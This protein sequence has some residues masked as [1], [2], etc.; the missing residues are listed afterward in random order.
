M[1]RSSMLALVS[2]LGLTACGKESTRPLPEPPA[3]QSVGLAPYA[4]LSDTVLVPVTAEGADSVSLLVD[5]GWVDSDR[6]VPFELR[7][8]T[9]GLP[10]GSHRVQVVATNRG[11][12]TD[13]TL[14]IL[15]ENPGMGIG[16][17]V[18]PGEATVG[19]GD[20]RQFEAV[21]VGTQDKRV[22]WSVTSMTPPV[23]GAEAPGVLPAAVEPYPGS[24]DTTGLYTA[25]AEDHPDLWITVWAVSEA[26]PQ[27]V[28][29]ARIRLRSQP[30]LEIAVPPAE[31][32][33][34]RTYAL[35]TSLYATD[36][37]GVVWSL[38]GG[39]GQ[40]SITADGT[41]TAPATL[42]DPPE[43]TIRADLASD[44]GRADTVALPIRAEYGLAITSP[45]D[46]LATGVTAAFAAEVD[47]PSDPTVLWS[48]DGGPSH[49]TI[50]ADGTYTAPAILPD[51][52]AAV[53][54]AV[55]RADTLRTE[56]V[57]VDLVA[58]PD[59]ATLAFLDVMTQSGYALSEVGDQVIGAVAFA[60]RWAAEV[61]GEPAPTTGTL[62]RSGGDFVYENEPTDRFRIEPASGPI[63]TVHV[64]TME[65]RDPDALSHWSPYPGGG[66]LAYGTLEFDVNV[67]GLLSLAVSQDSRPMNLPYKPGVVCDPPARIERTLTGWIELPEAGWVDLDLSNRGIVADCGYPD[68]EDTLSGS[69]TLEG[70]GRIVFDESRQ[71]F[72]WESEGFTP[73]GNIWHWR[74]EDTGTL[75]GNTY[76][77]TDTEIRGQLVGTTMTRAG[78][79]VNPDDFAISGRLLRNGEAFAGV[80]FSYPV[81]VGVRPPDAV[82]DFG[83]GLTRVLRPPSA[84]YSPP[85]L[86]D[87]IP[88]P[89]R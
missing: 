81:R 29:Q 78:D 1:K 83:Y 87:L 27:A 11:G 73:G 16:L 60:L 9:A 4:I 47:G 25:P 74:F 49:G 44:P 13:T 43:I 77:L 62:R 18:K 31:L 34:A 75:G 51:P 65:W 69:A 70:G 50:T 21:V 15:T 17:A 35:H 85:G 8:P 48:V 61:S 37:T 30:V 56:A 20:T 45:G 33:A 28:D 80:R 52:P 19:F 66:F 42:P 64:H 26:D 5:S 67:P 63:W 7:V 53:I 59:P 10:N 71:L 40:G 55:L 22:Q 6:T 58:G 89:F 38:P 14:T 84:G 23:P 86:H 3:L 72:R 54:R 79:V 39:A 46:T 24:V 36:E 12:A 32:V 82:L 68:Q 41:Y 57:Q 2:L 76:R 88:D